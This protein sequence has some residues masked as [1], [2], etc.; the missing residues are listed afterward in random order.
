M[1]SSVKPTFSISFTIRGILYEPPCFKCKSEDTASSEP[2]NDWLF[3][4]YI[5]FAI[6]ES[7]SASSSTIYPWDCALCKL[8][9]NRSIS[10][11][12]SACL[13]LLP[14]RLKFDSIL[15]SSFNRLQR[16]QVVKGSWTTSH[17]NWGTHSQPLTL[18]Q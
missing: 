16:E 7:M 14:T 5:P 3:L 4:E 10:F 2:I 15:Q 11:S 18:R 12:I 9:R 1:A 13:L 6:G 8:R 17:R